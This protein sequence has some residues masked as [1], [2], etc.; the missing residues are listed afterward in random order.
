M[1][2]PYYRTARSFDGDY[3]EALAPRRYLAEVLTHTQPKIRQRQGVSSEK[4]IMP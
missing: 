4:I 2:P 3:P 1:Q